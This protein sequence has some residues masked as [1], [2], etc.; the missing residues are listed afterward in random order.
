MIGTRLHRWLLVLLALA[1]PHGIAHAHVKWFSEFSYATPPR[2]LA[3]IVSPLF[4]GLAVLSMAVIAALV[5]V[6]RW[7]Q[8]RP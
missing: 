6:D 4:V 7:M 8:S 3:E 5:F 1:A 2:T